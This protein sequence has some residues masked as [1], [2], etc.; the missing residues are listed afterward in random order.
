MFRFFWNFKSKKILSCEYKDYNQ[1]C[2]FLS[3][4]QK[5]R[6]GK[7]RVICLKK[8]FNPTMKNY[9]VKLVFSST[10][11]REQHFVVKFIWNIN[12][13]MAW[14]KT[15]KIGCGIATQCD[16]GR[17][18]IVVCQYGPK[19]VKHHCY[20]KKKLLKNNNNSKGSV[21]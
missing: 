10:E 11:S 3:S 7:N 19:Y 4:C 13:Q 15:Y 8:I 20:N 9:M 14:G 2:Y 12:F 1:N 5:K 18:L 21:T 6:K 17:T 16:G